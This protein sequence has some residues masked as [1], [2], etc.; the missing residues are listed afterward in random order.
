MVLSVMQIPCLTARAATCIYYLKQC[1]Y[2]QTIF[3]VRVY[4]DNLM[5]CGDSITYLL[6]NVIF[7]VRLRFGHCYNVYAVGPIANTRGQGF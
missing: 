4:F 1:R 2:K 6:H 7:A 3:F 5:F